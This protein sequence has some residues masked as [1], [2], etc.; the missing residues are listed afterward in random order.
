MLESA[1]IDFKDQGMALSLKG[2]WLVD[3]VRHV[4][5]WIQQS[6]PSSSMVV[7]LDAENITRMDTAGAFL[8]YSLHQKL[9]QKNP[10]VQVFGLQ[11]KFQS[12]LELVSTE[13]TQVH[14][15]VV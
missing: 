7:T 8:L 15:T 5:A 13:L 4:D 6:I 9:L 11:S 1:S 14:E 10:N 12:L 2:A 3:E